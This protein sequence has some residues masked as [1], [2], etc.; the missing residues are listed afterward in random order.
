MKLDRFTQKCSELP[1]L[2]LL[3]G[4]SLYVAIVGDSRAI[5]VRHSHK[6]AVPPTPPGVGSLRDHPRANV[7]RHRHKAPVSDRSY[8]VKNMSREAPELG[9]ELDQSPR[10]IQHGVFERQQGSTTGHAGKPDERP[11]NQYLAVSD[12]PLS[13]EKHDPILAQV[14][15]RRVALVDL[16]A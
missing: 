6:G 16:A 14:I 13:I 8:L 7:S 5:L 10:P 2:C 12:Q 15:T 3:K 9:K 4:G 11:A 1:P